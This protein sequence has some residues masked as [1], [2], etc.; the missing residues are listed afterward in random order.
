MF[1]VNFYKIIKTLD[2]K[3]IKDMNIKMWRKAINVIPSISKQEWNALDLMSKWL[4]STR[5]A[6]L[7]MTVISAT[8][9]GLFAIRNGTFEFLPWLILTCS[10]IIQ[11]M[12]EV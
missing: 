5:A 12:S 10:M 4:I 3:A 11:I 2:R 9:A 1:V 6:V 7:V 8:L